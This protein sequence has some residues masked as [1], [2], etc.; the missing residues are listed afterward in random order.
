MAT[1]L[2]PRDPIFANLRTTSSKNRS[3]SA[4]EGHLGPLHN[5]KIKNWEAVGRP[6]ATPKRPRGLKTLPQGGPRESKE[7]P[8]DCFLVI[9]SVLDAI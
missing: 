9:Q 4:Q 2:G 3:K 5:P 1:K 7:G 6:R 8:Q